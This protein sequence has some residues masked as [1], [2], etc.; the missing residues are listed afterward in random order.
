MQ[1]RGRGENFTSGLFLPDDT[2]ISSK[3]N[4]GQP[5]NH[6]ADFLHNL[7][8]AIALDMNI[9]RWVVFQDFN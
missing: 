5:A 8:N 6:L 1:M 4:I 7:N 9:W 3:S 2:S